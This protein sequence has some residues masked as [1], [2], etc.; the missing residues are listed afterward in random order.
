M[1][2]LAVLLSAALAAAIV[3]CAA[4]AAAEDDRITREARA[5]Y[6]EGT[7]LY[8]IGRYQE[9]AQRF[10]DGYLKKSDASFLFNLAQ[11][12]RQMHEPEQAAREY[13]AYLRDKPDA[14]NRDDVETFIREADAELRR[15]APP[16]P[17]AHVVTPLAERTT[18]APASG[19]PVY[20]QWWLWTAVGG[21]L[22]V[23]LGVGLGVGL[24]QSSD[25]LFPTIVF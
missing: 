23:G 3:L 9:A 13:R 20:K 14:P 22:A 15:R 1:V 17:P 5:L 10:Q 7:R 11:C 4:P 8:K 24:S 21:A 6:V 2:R 25:H 19:A 18:P 12:Y 16:A